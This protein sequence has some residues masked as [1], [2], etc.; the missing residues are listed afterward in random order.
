[1]GGWIAEEMNW[2]VC[3]RVEC[4]VREKATHLTIL[5]KYK[6]VLIVLYLLK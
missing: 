4:N 5:L 6:S 2:T 1:M 3:G